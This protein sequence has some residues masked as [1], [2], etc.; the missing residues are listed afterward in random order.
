MNIKGAVVG[1]GFFAS[2]HILAWKELNNVEIIAVCDLDK[3]KALHFKKKYNIK[4]YFT[5][6]LEMIQSLELDFVDVITTMETHLNICKVLSTYKIP[7]CVQKPFS[8]TY[9]NAKKIVEMYEKNNTIIMVHENFRWQTPIITFKNSLTKYNL[10]KLIYSKISFRHS[11]PVGY[12]NQKY[13]YNLKKYLIFDVG[14]H[15]YD[16]ARLFMGEVISIYTINQNTNKKFKGETAF[17]SLL[18]HINN[19]VSIVDASISSIK[20]PDRFAQTLINI[21]CKNGSAILDYDYNITIHKNNKKI[22]VNA[23]PKKYKWIKK[24]WD[25]IQESVINTHKHFISCLIKNKNP[26][27]NGK[28][29]LKSLNIVFASYKSTKLNKVINLK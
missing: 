9:I 8:D 20:K 29:N 15:L 23:K 13:L 19:S 7:T 26:D 18:N 5:S 21:E 14:I 25:Q 24:P 3:K 12:T 27:T 16:L 4:F 10:G 1:C 17:T 28:D 22:K 2:N 11:N 6:L